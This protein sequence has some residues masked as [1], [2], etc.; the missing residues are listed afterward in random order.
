MKTLSYLTVIKISLYFLVP[1][2]GKSTT[3]K[4]EIIQSNVKSSKVEALK[5]RLENL[6]LWKPKKKKRRGVLSKPHDGSLI[7][8]RA[9]KF[10]HLGEH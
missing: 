10:R 4:K 6:L 1:W 7:G 3:R 2:V 9:E 8:R 5:G